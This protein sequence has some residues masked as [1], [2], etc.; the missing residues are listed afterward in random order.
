[1]ALHTSQDHVIQSA[2]VSGKTDFGY[3]LNNIFPLLDRFGPQRKAQNK[4]FYD[5]L[6]TDI[7]NGCIMPLFWAILKVSFGLVPEKQCSSY[8][9]KYF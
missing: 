6:R 4:K 5:R 8:S 1:M 3:A 7:V 2:F 9:G